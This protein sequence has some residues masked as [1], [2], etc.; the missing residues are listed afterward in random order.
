MVWRATFTVYLV[1]LRILHNN[2][3]VIKG[4][5]WFRNT[6]PAL[7]QIK[8]LI[9]L[10][11]NMLTFASP[12]FLALYCAFWSFP[13]PPLFGDS[14]FPLTNKFAAGGPKPHPTWNFFYSPFLIYFLL[15][16]F[17][18]LFFFPKLLI[19][20]FSPANHPHPPYH[21]ILHNIYPWLY[22]YGVQC[23]ILN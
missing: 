12:F 18:F 6:L 21:S 5:M 8:L 1:V 15:F 19:L 13:P 23:S 10:R 4:I 22:L 20:F 17:P 11:F 3:A 7:L 9:W 2:S 16:S 14:F